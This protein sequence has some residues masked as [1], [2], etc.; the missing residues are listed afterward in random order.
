MRSLEMN[1][2]WSGSTACLQVWARAAAERIP[3]GHGQARGHE[4]AS[5]VEW[6]PGG[7]CVRLL[8]G[9][10]GLLQAVAEAVALAAETEVN[11]ALA[12]HCGWRGRWF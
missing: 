10:E 9:M 12:K 6:H 7:G 8:R 3:A 5:E 4:G 1:D 2:R 11:N